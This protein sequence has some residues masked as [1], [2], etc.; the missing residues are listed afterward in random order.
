[1][2]GDR[3]E[4][5]MGEARVDHIGNQPLAH[6]V[7]GQEGA[8]VAPLPRTGM[9]FVDRHRLAACIGVAPEAAVRLVAP[10]MGERR[11]G[12]R[13]RGRPQFRTKGKRVG[14]QRQLLALWP[15][16][17]EFVGA[18]RAD[19][20]HEDLPD[21]DVLALAHG[22]PAAVPFVEVAHHRDA[23]RIGRP[24]REMDARCAFMVDKMGAELVE[25]PQMRAFGD[26]VVVH[27]T[28]H[29]PEGI[30][31]GHP[32]F[33]AGVARQKFQRCARGCRNRAFEETG[34]V[35]AGQ[36]AQRRPVKRV[37][38][39]GLGVRYEAARDERPFRSLNTENRECV[40]M[41]AGDDRLDVAF[42]CPDEGLLRRGR[43]ARLLHS[44]SALLHVAVLLFRQPSCNSDHTGMF[45]ISFAYWRMVRS[46]ENHPM[47]AT[48]WIA[49]SYQT[50]LL[51]QVA[52]TSRC[53]AA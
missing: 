5:D 27:R 21:A 45:Q 1:M 14:L 51:R 18:S 29:G 47:R 39:N 19:I 38:R 3:H 43:R 34:I 33:A 4:L 28:E 53:A 6:L 13:G 40:A 11:G 46:D 9:D 52:S 30:G 7:P 15:E 23:A 8:V 36:F 48:L 24:Y 16:D 2:L 37:G 12:D 17:L 31:V 25:Q 42:G 35:A 32:P 49:F 50:G 41:C 22:M 20:G 10:F 26:V 44:R